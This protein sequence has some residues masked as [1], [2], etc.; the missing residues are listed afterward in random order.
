MVTTK[1]KRSKG[2]EGLVSKYNPQ[3][4]EEGRIEV[5][6]EGKFSSLLKKYEEFL[7]LNHGEFENRYMGEEKFIRNDNDIDDILQPT[8]I[9]AFTLLTD[10]YKDNLWE[11]ALFI[12]KLIQNSYNAGF[13]NFR[14]GDCSEI[15]DLCAYL[16]GKDK[17]ISVKIEG[18]AGE[19]CGSGA[20][21]LTISI[22][23]NA[24]DFCGEYAE[25]STITIGGNAGVRCAWRANNSTI[26]IEGN[27][28]YG[29]GLMAKNSTFKTSNADTLQKLKRH[30][31]KGNKIIFIN[32]G[33]EEVV[34]DYAE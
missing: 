24:G 31:P 30:V 20:N 16:E 13:N 14:L 6:G 2:I 5:V 8:K 12:N 1:I 15:S 10:R 28:G 17:P 27:T 22:A 3:T 11:T 33:R 25:D 18:D 19:D 34:R 29:C 21:N 26:T 9:M 32:N 4:V 23:G 7:N